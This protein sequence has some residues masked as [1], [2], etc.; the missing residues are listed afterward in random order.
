MILISGGI[1][2]R[3]YEGTGVSMTTAPSWLFIATMVSAWLC[4][5]R[6]VVSPL[7]ERAGVDLIGR[8]EAG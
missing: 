5:R 7:R 8:S 1:V 4:A 6:K 2:E 3:H